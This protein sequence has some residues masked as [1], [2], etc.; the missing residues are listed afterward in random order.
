[1]EALYLQLVA[2]TKE[3]TE[4]CLAFANQLESQQEKNAALSETNDRV[5]R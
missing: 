2:N 1:M 5:I 3:I 4:E